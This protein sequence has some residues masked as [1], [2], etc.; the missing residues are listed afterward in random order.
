MTE[1]RR[2]K[3]AGEQR[4]EAKPGFPGILDACANRQCK[5]MRSYLQRGEGDKVVSLACRTQHFEVAKPG[6]D[7]LVA[8]KDLVRA[9]E[10]ASGAMNARIGRYAEDSCAN[11]VAADGIKG[12]LEACGERRARRLVDALILRDPKAAERIAD[13]GPDSIAAYAKLRLEQERS[14]SEA[15]AKR[16]G[17][18]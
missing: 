10:I 3:P 15:K 16:T 7:G 6:V 5:L 13:E 14:R 9:M 2:A 17:K 1:T 8:G 18:K 12:V 4:G 11:A